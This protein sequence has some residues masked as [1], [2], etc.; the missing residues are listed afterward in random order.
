M[1]RLLGRMPYYAVREGKSVG[2][3]QTWKE[4]QEQ[5]SGYSGAKYKKFE[6]EKEAQSYINHRD[7]TIHQTKKTTGFKLKSNVPIP[8]LQC[9][10]PEGF[11]VDECKEKE[12]T[13]ERKTKLIEP[14]RTANYRV[15][16]YNDFPTAPVV[17][18][19]GCCLNNGKDK[20]VAGIGVWWAPGHPMNV[21]EYL[22]VENPTNNKAELS[23]A[24]RALQDAQRMN[25]T[26]LE[27]RTDSIYLI[28]CVTEWIEDWKKKGR[29]NPEH[30]KA[31]CNIG[32]I[33]ELE[34]LCNH[35]SVLWVHVRGH[36]G[37]YG[38]EEADKLSKAGA[39]KK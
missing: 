12:H 5:V 1:L 29:L 18:T 35:L 16:S 14:P 38:N 32:L 30:P 39:S 36:E 4:C 21:G 6:T 19:D 13:K 20:A 24:I 3:Y 31:V 23:A 7:S 34:R 10:N 33:K 17:Y 22:D 11:P 26:S 27:L 8:R 2:I 9:L 25:L 37:V 28:N 15:K